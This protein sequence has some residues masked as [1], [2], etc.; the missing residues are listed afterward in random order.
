MSS[1]IIVAVF[2]IGA[3]LLAWNWQKSHANAGVVDVV[4][5]FGMMFA[6]PWYAL[7]GT[8]P[9]FLKL[10]LGVLTFSWFWRLGR[11]LQR[12]VFKETEDGRYH[13]M[14]KAM[15]DRADLGFLLFFLLQAGFIWLLSLPFWAVAQNSRPQ[16]SLVVAA[17]LLAALAL[18]GETTADQQL[19][20]FRKKPQHR[21]LS[22]RE[23]WWRY[24]RHPN[25][26][27][28]WLHWFQYWLWLA[29]V[30][31]FC[32][33]YWFTG[34]PFTEQ[35][36]LRSRGEDYRLYQKTTSMFFPWWPET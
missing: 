21:G 13:A 27:F 26:F 20:E 7:T 17:L 18:Y 16:T 33:L 24:S 6:G 1:L 23:G 3:M 34:I 9:L 10:S 25:Y 32:F 11:H 28:E 29:P 12:R 19:A 36:A 22:C 30:V 4:W 15:K 5:A 31:M 35:Q 2:S 8:A 14:R